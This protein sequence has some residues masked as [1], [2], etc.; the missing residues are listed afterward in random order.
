MRSKLAAICL[1]AVGVAW[2]WSA[3]AHE[4]DSSPREAPPSRPRPAGANEAI[5]KDVAEGW[6]EL[7]RAFPFAK[8]PTES[9]P[10][11]AVVH[12]QATLGTPANGLLLG[13]AQQINSPSGSV[14]VIPGKRNSE[15]LVCVLQGIEG[16]IG[17]TSLLKFAARGLALGM[18]KPSRLKG[19][20]PQDFRVLGVAPDWVEVVR[21]NVGTDGLRDVP[22][23]SGVYGHRA[24]APILIE[25]F[26]SRDRRVCRS[27]RTKSS[28]TRKP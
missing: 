16:Y 7:H 22:V 15:K 21:V 14:W 25:R 28:Q 8:S 1:F 24:A 23:R 11:R 19:E 2:V 10:A 18:A 6:G 13:H 20:P 12:L 17:C 3:C 5:A 26:C 27:L 4:D 9:L